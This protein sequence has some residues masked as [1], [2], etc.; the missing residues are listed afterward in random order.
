MGNFFGY[1]SKDKYNVDLILEPLKSKIN[2]I[3]NNSYKER[4]HQI[5]TTNDL[6]KWK[7]D[8]I[9]LILK[10]IDLFKYEL[11]QLINNLNQ[12]EPIKAEEHIEQN[13][14]LKSQ[15]EKNRILGQNKQLTGD[16]SHLH[17]NQN[18]Q[19]T[20]NKYKKT[21]DSNYNKKSNQ[22]NVGQNRRAVDTKFYPSNNK[23]IEQNREVT[24]S[25]FYQTNNNQNIEESTGSILNRK[26]YINRNKRLDIFTSKD[27]QEEN[28][29]ITRVFQKEALNYTNDNEEVENETIAK[30]LINVANVS[31][32]AYNNSNELFIK[33][34]EEF[35]KSTEERKTISDLKNDEQFRKEFSS[36][37]KEFEKGVEGKQ[38]YK[39]YFNSFKGKGN[40]AK[41]NYI[42][43]LLS[44]LTKLYFHC[45]LSFPIVDVDF[46]LNSKI[47]FNHEKMIDFI[48]KGNNRKVNFVILPSLFSDNNYLENGKFWVFT[49]KKDTFKFDKLTFENLVNKQEKYISPQNRETI[50]SKYYQSNNQNIEQKRESTNSKYY[51]F[52]RSNI[53]QKR[54][55]ND[56]KFDQYNNLN[57]DQNE[58]T[59][60][61]KF[62]HSNKRNIEENREVTNSKVYQSNNKNICQNAQT[63]VSKLNRIS[64]INKRLDVFTSKDIQEE[65]KEITRIFQKEAL[66]YIDDNEEEENETIAKFLIKVAN[67][68]RRAYNNSNE[69]FIKIFEEFSKSIEKIKAISDLKNDEQFRK[70]FSSWVKE[71]EKKSEGK[72]KYKDYFNSFKGKGNYAKESYI[73]ELHSQ[74]TILY[75]H[76]ELSF[77]IV[78]V[79]FDLNSEIIFNHEKMIDFIN[80]GNNRKVDFLILPSLFSN[81]NYLENGKF[82]VFTFKK[83][84]FKFGKLTFE[85]LV[86]KQEK[87]NAIYSKNNL[88]TS[89]TS[90]R[91]F[92]LPRKQTNNSINS[93]KNS[94]LIER[95][96]KYYKHY[97]DK[98]KIIII[99]K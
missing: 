19:L 65:N 81:G 74:L 8:I 68:S 1:Y 30:F 67:V 10:E 35:S 97:I 83:G 61:N 14:R 75:F 76:C 60:G 87:Y 72:Q 6:Y 82:W 33:I 11:K 26:S 36:W 32:R 12:Q 90:N 71:Y 73:P 29:K 70:E 51:Q 80:K 46:K 98:N 62:I 45:E 13:M 17:N 54:E 16:K 25:K 3:V 15:K 38:K 64:N 63:I 5:K 7:N 55:Y 22:N 79:N 58:Q 95:K 88:P 49:F 20:D 59:T 52:N 89:G 28:K 86:D 78:D 43:E 2:S 99:K 39:N 40:Y 50:D 53:G 9:F 4:Y 93:N 44:Q 23:N 94:N 21:I 48:N 24:N 96:I 77:P 18:K 34:F 31:R 41:E 84:T 42:P 27:I 91:E 37:V 85:N 69:L 57:I 92:N 56:S 66:N 47:I